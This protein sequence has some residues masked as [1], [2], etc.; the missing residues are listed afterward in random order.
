[1]KKRNKRQARYDSELVVIE[2]LAIGWSNL[3]VDLI[4]EWW[5]IG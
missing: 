1:M 2:T 4:R 5:K 3:K